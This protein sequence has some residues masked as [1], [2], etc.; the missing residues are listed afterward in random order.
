MRFTNGLVLS[1]NIGACG[2][3]DNHDMTEFDNQHVETDTVECAVWIDDPEQ[4][5]GRNW[6]TKT[7]FQDAE[8]G[9]ASVVGYVSMQEFQDALPKIMGWHP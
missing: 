9:F 5:R 1:M 7:F 6:I 4:S 3:N 2:Y 8:D